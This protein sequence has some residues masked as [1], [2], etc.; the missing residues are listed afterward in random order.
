MD[1]GAAAEL[2]NWILY[3]TEAVWR[4]QVFFVRIGVIAAAAAVGRVEVVCVCVG[5]G[6]VKMDVILQSKDSFIV[7]GRGLVQKGAEI[8]KSRGDQP[9][10]G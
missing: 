2:V 4:K 10:A 1:C 9:H 3:R 6:G 7:S 5:G 8:G